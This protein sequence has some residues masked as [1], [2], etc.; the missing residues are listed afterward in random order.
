MAHVQLSG[1]V[2]LYLL[3]M[4]G[5]FQYVHDSM[6]VTRHMH[7]TCMKTLYYVA[8]ASVG[9]HSAA[10]LRLTGRVWTGRGDEPGRV[11]G[12]NYLQELSHDVHCVCYFDV[13]RIAVL[14]IIAWL[15]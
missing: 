8:S 6:L 11:R 15:C 10:R 2:Q 7:E 12:V 3:Y 14:Q 4:K 13:R 1:L 9:L 5:I